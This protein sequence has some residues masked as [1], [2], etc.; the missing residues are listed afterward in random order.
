MLD[1][2]FIRDNADI[3][4]KAIERKKAPITVETLISLDDKRLAVLAEVESLRAQQNEATK[5]MATASAETREDII[6]EMKTLKA[7]L[8]EKEEELKTITTKW[9]KMMLEVPNLIDVAVPDGDSD[10]DNLEIKTWG[11]KPD[12]SFKP[13]DH[14][15]LM[16]KLNLADFERGVKV[17][18]FRG[19]FL[20]NDGL[21]L[22]MALWQ[23]ALDMLR[24]DNFQLMLAPS[25][26]RRP[27]FF[28]T[29]YLPQGE[30]D[31]YQTQDG[32][33]LAGTSEVA[34]MAGHMDE[35]LTKDQL[36]LRVGAWSPCFRREAGSYGKDTKGLIR[37]HEFYKVEQVILCPA[38]HEASVAEHEAL[39][40]RAEKL[41]QALQLPYRVVVNCAGDLGLGQVKKY[42]IEAWMPSESKYRE[43]HSI[44]YFHDWQTRRLNIKYRDEKGQLHLAHSLNGTMAATPRLLAAILENNQDESGQITVPEV[45]RPYIGKTLIN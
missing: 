19:Y 31:L 11:Q 12:M 6:R 34:V 14:K 9:Q 35:V 16:E 21:S 3:I 25:L 10:E 28:G 39:L 29:G 32:D 2:K 33:F 27:G 44:S 42:D 24:Q 20:K 17:H 26:V 37:V 5:N 4:A 45:L 30:E 18:G 1:I 38:S 22:S 43:T 36:P 23:Y 15:E 7:E 13:A 40:A 41:M 8:K